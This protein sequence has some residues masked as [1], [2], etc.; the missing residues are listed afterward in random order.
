MKIILLSAALHNKC[1]LLLLNPRSK[2]GQSKSNLNLNQNHQSTNSGGPLM[3]NLLI[4]PSLT[5]NNKSDPADT[6]PLQS[7][8]DGTPRHQIGT[9]T[10]KHFN[11]V[12]FK[13][14]LHITTTMTNCVDFHTLAVTRN[15]CGTMKSRTTFEAQA[16]QRK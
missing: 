13:V 4:P 9:T 1:L 15:K 10:H 11:N 6:D 2:E 8:D 5:K 14:K 12:E 3:G 7:E 16:T